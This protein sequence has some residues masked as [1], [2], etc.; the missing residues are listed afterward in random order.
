M[1]AQ[2]NYLDLKFEDNGDYYLINSYL[3]LEK[4]DENDFIDELI[5]DHPVELLATATHANIP[6]NE[7]A[8][9]VVKEAAGY[10]CFRTTSLREIMAYFDQYY[11]IPQEK[12]KAVLAAARRL[13]LKMKRTHA[14]Q[15]NG[16]VEV[17]TRQEDTPILPL[18][19]KVEES[20]LSPF[21]FDDE[22]Q[23][24]RKKKRNRM[25]AQNSR[26]RK[27]EYIR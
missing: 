23:E 18:E 7:Y 20:E 15:R 14:R 24:T 3:G 2:S 11:R 4:N 10:V 13:K 19:I 12:I 6:P 21:V 5:E 16:A 17:R 9:Q 25:S 8:E 26:D 1:A 27:K 22:S